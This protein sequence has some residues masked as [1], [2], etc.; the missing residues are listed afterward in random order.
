MKSEPT[1]LRSGAK[2]VLLCSQ[3]NQTKPAS[4]NDWRFCLFVVV[5]F[6]FFLGVEGL[7]GRCMFLIVTCVGPKHSDAMLFDDIIILNVFD[8]GALLSSSILTVCWTFLV[9]VSAP[10]PQL[11]PTP[12]L[13]RYTLATETHSYSDTFFDW[14]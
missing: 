5:R 12:V 7:G 8:L 6:S 11:R 14:Q 10:C 3:K 1:R 13:C 2:Q 4:G 9:D